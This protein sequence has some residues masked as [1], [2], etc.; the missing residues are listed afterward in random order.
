MKRILPFL[1][2][3]LSASVAFG[4]HAGIWKSTN[5]TNNFYLQTYK[6]DNS[7]LV[8]V[9]PDAVSQW[10]VFHDTNIADGIDV[11]EMTGKPARLILYLNSKTD[12]VADLTVSGQSTVYDLK[13]VSEA[14]SR[15]IGGSNPA[16]PPTPPNVDHRG[17]YELAFSIIKCSNGA[18]LTNDDINGSGIF[19]CDG[20]NYTYTTTVDGWTKSETKS[21]SIRWTST[22]EAKVSFGDGNHE[23]WTVQGYTAVTKYDIKVNGISCEAWDSW[24]KVSDDY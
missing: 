24:S 10:Y 4:G 1:L 21:Y 2:L 20:S 5:P 7:I 17:T 23:T 14:D 18:V 13:R 8:I 11:A 9:T 12:I 22:N 16:A 6:G 19:I 3:V 15:V